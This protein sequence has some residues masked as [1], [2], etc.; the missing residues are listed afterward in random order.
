MVYRIDSSQSAAKEFSFSGLLDRNAL[1]ILAELGRRNGGATL[2]L[3][4]GTEVV[5]E[6]IPGLLALHLHVTAESPYLANWL[7]RAR[8]GQP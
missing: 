7:A 8:G 1:A 5:A 4:A 2:V 3:R 6:C